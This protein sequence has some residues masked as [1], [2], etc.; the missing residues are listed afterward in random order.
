MRLTVR[1]TAALAFLG[2]T[3]HAARAQTADPS[4]WGLVRFN[5]DTAHSAVRF[6][7]R[8]LGISWVHGEFRGFTMDL[9]YDH[10]S[11]ERSTVSARIPT[12]TINTGN[13]RRDGDLRGSNYLGVDSFPEMTFVSRRVERAGT[14][15]LL[16][17]GDLTLRGVTRSVTLDTEVGGALSGQRGRR[18][19]FSASTVI[20][21]QDFGVTFNRLVEGAQV[22][23]DDVR[24][25]IEIEATAPNT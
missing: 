14:G 9:S 2:F 1:T 19:A 23:G 6:Q 24:I 20:R 5:L 16:I 25:T 13:Q 10:G 11:P 17:T 7:V 12:A 8:H 21:R 22:V 15:R 18:V 4:S 3:A